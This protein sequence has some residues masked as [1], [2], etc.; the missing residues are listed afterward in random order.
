[1]C[2]RCSG[3]AS[4]SQSTLNSP[5]QTYTYTNDQ[6]FKPDQYAD[7]IVAYKNNRRS[8]RD[9]GSVVSAGENG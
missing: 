7:L 1:M 8:V 2:A 3:K 9:I 6:I 4:I 5:R